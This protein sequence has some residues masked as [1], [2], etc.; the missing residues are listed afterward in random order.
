MTS[1]CPG[2]S[3][4]TSRLRMPAQPTRRQFSRVNTDL[5]VPTLLTV[6]DNLQGPLDDATIVRS[7][8]PDGSRTATSTVEQLFDVSDSYGTAYTHAP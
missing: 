6:A 2:W 1:C 5:S 4:D 7:G 3:G 8:R